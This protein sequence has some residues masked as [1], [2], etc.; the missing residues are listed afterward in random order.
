MS[1]LDSLDRH[2]GGSWIHRFDARAQIVFYFCLTT[3][4][5]FASDFR[6][7]GGLCVVPIGI[8]LSGKLNWRQTRKHWFWLFAFVGI[9]T[10]LYL[11]MGSET[12]FVIAYALR[13]LSVFLATIILTQTIDQRECGCALRG[14]GV[15]DKLAF[16]LNL[17]MRYI[18]TLK[19][20]FDATVDAQKARGFEL[21]G[22]ECGRIRRLIRMRA[23]LVPVF[24]RSLVESFDVASA[25]EMR[26]FGAEKPRTWL[27]H[28]RLSGR[29][30]V[31]IAGGL[32]LLSVCVASRVLL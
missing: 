21:D 5:L 29:D 30:L 31:A 23:L 2:Q 14:L 17:M 8:A 22:G 12:S 26:A 15:P 16:A 18:D 10:T 20:D 11:V 19:H 1:A 25:M 9:S 13:M 7:L 27:H 3:G 24:A 6:V 28:S 4:A 32:I